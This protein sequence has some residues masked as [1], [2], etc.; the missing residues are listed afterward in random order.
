MPGKHAVRQFGLPRYSFTVAAAAIL[1]AL[2]AWVA[3]RAAGPTRDRTP[4]LIE[5]S[6]SATAIAAHAL[7]IVSAG[8]SS[9]TPSA[10]PRVTSA[11]PV[12]KK[13]ERATTKPPALAPTRTKSPPAPAAT[14]AADYRTSIE[15]RRSFMVAIQ[16]TN[17]GTTPDDFRVSLTYA[18]GDGVQLT[19]V[20]NGELS[21]SGDTWTITGGTLAP[22]ASTIVGFQAT[23]QTR[24]GVRPSGCAVN[25]TPCRVG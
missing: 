9:R 2:V 19:G 11:S 5:P 23:K 13:T 8:P 14:L 25:G 12:P 7:P 24:D 4:I 22:G 21:H 10:T 15:G 16:V 3:I 18:P 20:W 6:A 17:T 1:L